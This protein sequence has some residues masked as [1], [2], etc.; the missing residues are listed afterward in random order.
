[1]SKVQI[2]VEGI[3][4]AKL[5]QDIIKSWYNVNLKIGKIGSE[6]V[7]PDILIVGGK[8][9]IKKI[10]NQ[11][12]EN[13]EFEIINVIIFDADI[14]KE[15]NEKFIELKKYFPIQYFL[16]PDNQSNGDLETLLVQIINQENSVIFDCWEG[17][18]NCLKTSKRK[19]GVFTTP[20]S[21]TKIYAYLEA[22]LGESDSQK[23]K[24]KEA[25]RNYQDAT[26]W[27]LNAPALVNLKQFLDQYF[28][29]LP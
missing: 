13:N 15:E 17:Y 16:L 12:K 19:D 26:H 1:M 25:E 21:K 20:A 11:F 7:N 5:I 27:D 22:L 3:D 6:D 2:F 24:I 14:F 10:A 18:E 4:D 8:G 23:K 29:K 9:N 28:Q